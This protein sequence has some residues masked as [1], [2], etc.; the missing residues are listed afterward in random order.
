MQFLK[1]SIV[2]FI[3]AQAIAFTGTECFQSSFDVSV[4]HKSAPFGLLNKTI[5]I[6]KKECEIEIAHNQYK[7]MNRNW[8]IDICRDPI[9]VKSTSNSVDVFRKEGECHA[10]SNEFCDEY[11]TIKK[12]IE[13][14]GLIFASG[15]KNSLNDDHGRVFCAKLLVEE[16]LNAN[17]VFSRN[18]NYDYIMI[19]KPIA[20][21]PEDL[22]RKRSE[23]KPVVEK[24]EVKE[25]NGQEQ[26]TIE[27]SGDFQI[28]ESAG[29]GTF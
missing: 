16:Y 25:D 6:S 19:R 20:R 11:K 3:T 27:S 13:D 22:K 17:T 9:H 24:T 8:L 2:F 26:P 10:T 4:K 28:D 21:I 23:F 5:T 18:G 29:P 14:D 12:I 7:Y 15:A 1:S